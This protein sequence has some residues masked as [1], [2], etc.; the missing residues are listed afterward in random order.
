MIRNKLQDVPPYPIGFEVISYFIP[1]ECGKIRQV[2]K[3]EKDKRCSSGWRIWL[4]GLEIENGI[5]AAW[6]RGIK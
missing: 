2:L 6:A 1:S 3:V 5:C 4:T